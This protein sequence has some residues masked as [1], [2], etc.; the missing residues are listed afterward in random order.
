MLLLL[1]L[2]VMLMIP[3]LMMV[4]CFCI[5]TTFFRTGSFESM[6]MIM[7]L[8]F[9]MWSHSWCSWSYRRAGRRFVVID[10]DVIIFLHQEGKPWSWEAIVNV[11]VI[12]DGVNYDIDDSFCCFFIRRVNLGAGRRFQQTRR[13]SPQTSPHLSSLLIRITTRS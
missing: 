13:T 8:K 2:T 5:T 10:Y 4:L 7:F 9:S 11:V 1:L 6:M 3:L 12:V